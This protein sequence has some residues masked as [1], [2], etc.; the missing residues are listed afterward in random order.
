MGQILAYSANS[1][2]QGFHVGRM[3]KLELPFLQ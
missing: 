2:A 3:E 1:N